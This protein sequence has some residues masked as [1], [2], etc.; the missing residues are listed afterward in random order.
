MNFL[1]TKF[2][3]EMGA[4]CLIIPLLCV[5]LLGQNVYAAEYDPLEV[6]IPFLHVYT[7]TD[8][9]V[10]S[11]FHYQVTAEN[12]A[13][14]PK[15]ANENGTF[16]YQGVQGSGTSVTG[17]T[18]FEL[19][20]SLNFEFTKPGVY[21]YVLKADK[22][23]DADK[24]ADKNYT[25]EPREYKFSIYIENDADGKL[26]LSM[27]TSEVGGEKTTGIELDPSYHA[28][29]PD[30]PVPPGP[31]PPGPFPPTP[32]RPTPVT[33]T[34]PDV[35]PTPHTGD[36]SNVPLYLVL[37]GISLVGV[38]IVAAIPSKKKGRE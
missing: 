32:I 37:L 34:Q 20:G 18:R 33:P 21:S 25:L 28:E 16:A 6:T 10:D 9:Q 14:M 12:G 17:G 4:L 19:E 36:S 30:E 27:L 13:P 5:L 29:K 11:L 22:T 1:K 8:T 7:T 2:A 24:A 26:R 23:A 38:I 3:K 35:P 15:E 31:I